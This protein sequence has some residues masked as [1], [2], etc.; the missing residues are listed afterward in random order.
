MSIVLRDLF[1]LENQ[2]PFEI[3][4]D[5]IKLRY[6]EGA[7][8]ALVNRFLNRFA[9]GASE[10]ER[11]LRSKHEGEP[12][13]LLEALHRVL[14]SDWFRVEDPAENVHPGTCSIC[15]FLCCCAVQETEGYQPIYTNVDTNEDPTNLQSWNRGWWGVGRERRPEVGPR[16]DL[17][18][19]IHSFRSVTDLMAKGIKFG[20]SSSQSL[21]DVK[22]E[23]G[24][25][26]ARLEL[27]TRIIV[28][29]T[30]IFFLNM[31][32]YE[33]SPDYHKNNVVTSYINL[34]KSLIEST[35]DV[36]ELREK[37]ILYN[38]L[39]SDEEVLEVFKEIKTYS[40]DDF[41]IFHNV[42]DEIEAHCSSTT[43]TWIGELNHKYFGSP[44]SCIGLLAAIV[45]F[46]IAIFNL[47]YSTH[48]RSNK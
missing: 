1:L 23:S 24:L 15:G 26:C 39:G 46:A 13:H 19:Y 7:G 4:K 48:K 10:L 38:A 31:I 2:I 30:K 34:M 36:K 18:K 35:E 16:R 25:F 11:R 32:A 44:W 41:K 9:F 37:K 43:K 17:R 27:P 21:K 33:L 14:V 20:P 3:V 22:F 12:L 29:N 8:E 45:L 42:K 28:M 40:V 5:L 6:G 47:Y